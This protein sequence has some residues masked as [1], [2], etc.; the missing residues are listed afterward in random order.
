M[1]TN[2]TIGKKYNAD[3]CVQKKLTASKSTYSEKNEN[4]RH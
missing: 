1:E 4:T 3:F 2:L